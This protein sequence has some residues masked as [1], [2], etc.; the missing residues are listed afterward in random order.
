MVGWE[1]VASETGLMVAGLK[2]GWVKVGLECDWKM[3]TGVKCD[4]MVG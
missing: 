2:H 1:W 4:W 3:R